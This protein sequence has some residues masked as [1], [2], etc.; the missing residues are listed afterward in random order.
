[1]IIKIKSYKII[2]NLVLSCIK[3]SINYCN[4]E[5]I[6]ELKIPNNPLVDCDILS[7]H[8][9]EITE[10]SNKLFKIIENKEY[11]MNTLIELRKLFMWLTS[12]NIS[13]N[14]EITN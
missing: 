10:V 7:F 1:M 4:N 13:L 14:N 5:I 8:N 6:F 2:K 9:L 3:L 11:S 12:N